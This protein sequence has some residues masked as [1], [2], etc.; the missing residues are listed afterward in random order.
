MVHLRSGADPC[1]AAYY[2]VP[3]GMIIVFRFMKELVFNRE[4]VLVVYAYG[5]P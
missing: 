2:N 1:G 5:C 3:F 4:Y